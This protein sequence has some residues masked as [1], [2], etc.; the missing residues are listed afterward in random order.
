[1]SRSTTSR[2][3]G[4]RE[5]SKINF[6]RDFLGPR[7]R[8]LRLEPL[9]PRRVLNAFSGLAG[10]LQS[11]V[12]SIQSSLDDAIGTLK[13]IPFVG[14]QL[15]TLDQVQNFIDAS[16]NKIQNSLN[17]FSSFT[18]NI[19]NDLQSTLYQAFGSP[20]LKILGRRWRLARRQ[21]KRLGQRHPRQRHANRPVHGATHAGDGRDAAG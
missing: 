21:P 19:A 7:L 6:V 1:M 4:M 11:E 2:R 9:E 12:A 16:G 5:T 20:G 14:T 17:N 8:P 15:G 18:G 10:N 13:S 3:K